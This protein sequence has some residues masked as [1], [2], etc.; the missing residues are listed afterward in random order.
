MSQTIKIK[1]GMMDIRIIAFLFTILLISNG[2]YK[3][4]IIFTPDEIPPVLQTGNIGDFYERLPDKF[5]SLSFD[6]SVDFVMATENNTIFQI[7]AGSFVDDSGNLVTGEVDFKYIEV[8]DHADYLYYKL[9]TISGK[10]L[11]RTEGV[12]RFEVTQENKKLKLKEGKGITVRLPSDDP[13]PGMMLFEAQGEGENFD[14]VLNQDIN[15]GQD[16]NIFINEW[17]VN[18]D[19]ASQEFLSGFGYQFDC[20]IF[21]WINV[22]IFSDVPEEDRTTVCVELPEIYTN[23]NTI[24]FMYFNDSESILALYGDADKMMWCEPYGATP[25]GFK[26]TFIV[27][28]SIEE[29][30]FHFALQEAVIREEHVEY[31]EPEEASF[32]DIIKAIEDL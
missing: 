18:L 28:A 32:E 19:S 25:K 12:F 14:W 6:A 8:L 22:D 15:T 29:D 27:I 13:D 21:K 11:L 20:D 10:K 9:P 23:E 30:V 5:D 3:D 4:D 2:C 7:A 17:F 31:I 24:V 1:K 16:Q 26:V